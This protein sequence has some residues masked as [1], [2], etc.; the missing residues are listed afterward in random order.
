MEKVAAPAPVHAAAKTQHP[1]EK[2]P[3][4]KT[5]TKRVDFGF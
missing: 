1:V 4:P 5:G 3:A 2:P